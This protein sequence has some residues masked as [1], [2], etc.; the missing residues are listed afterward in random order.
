MSIQ[1]KCAL[2]AAFIETTAGTSESHYVVM[3]HPGEWQIDA[4]YFTPNAT[5]SGHASNTVTLSAK[6]GSTAV[7]T[8]ILIDDGTAGTDGVTAGTKLTF[9]VASAGASLVFGQGDILHVAA[10][11]AASG[12]KCVGDMTVSFKQVVS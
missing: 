2:Q 12:I 4:C 8:A 3:P 1:S 9:T 5:V 10:T 7:C 6:Q 11:K